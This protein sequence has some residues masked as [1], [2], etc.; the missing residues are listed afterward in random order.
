MTALVR[1]DINIEYDSETGDYY[2]VWEPLV[3]GAGKTESEA[4]EDLK[5]AAH[6][7]VETLIDL[8]LKNIKKED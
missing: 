5:M 8:K 7:G 6:S 4:L 1:N 2:I 3:I